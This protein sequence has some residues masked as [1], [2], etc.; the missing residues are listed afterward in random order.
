MGGK[1]PNAWGLY[2][3]TGNVMEWCHDRPGYGGDALRG[4]KWAEDADN[5][6]RSGK[7][8]WGSRSSYGGNGTGFR[9][10]LSPTGM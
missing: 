3:M 6:I 2:D 5:N 9:V 1:Q 8:V 7:R 4:G 10:T